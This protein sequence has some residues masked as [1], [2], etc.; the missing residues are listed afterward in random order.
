MIFFA[1]S[2]KKTF[3]NAFGFESPIFD[4]SVKM[5][6]QS[7]W[8]ELSKVQS[9]GIIFNTG[10]N[11]FELTS[12][13]QKSGY[14]YKKISVVAQFVVN[15]CRGESTPEDIELANHFIRYF[16]E[17]IFIENN[18]VKRLGGSKRK[19]RKRTV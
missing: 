8:A 9:P 14:F 13:I 16:K 1:L 5:L 2:G 6:R 18:F 3:Y 4:E 17:K 7:T 12:K 11:N 15:T 10:F 19:T